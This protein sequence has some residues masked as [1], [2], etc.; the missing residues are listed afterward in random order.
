M[1]RN[2]TLFLITL[3]LNLTFIGNLNAQLIVTDASE[4]NGWTA[5]S[6]VRN[7]LLD[8]G[9][10]ISNAK[11]NG[12]DG[13]IDCNL[14]GKFETGSTPTNIG[15]ESGLILA[16]GGVSVAVGPNDTDEMIVPSTCAAYY[17]ENLASIASGPTTDVAVLEF[18]FIPWDNRVTFSFVFGS[19]EYMEW[20]GWD[21][22]D[23]FGFFVDGIN[24]AGSVYEHQNMA[25]VPGTAEIVSINTVNLNHN[26]AY[27]IDNTG[28]ATIQFDGFT[29]LMEVSFDVVPMSSYHIKM[30]ICDVGDDYADSGVFLKAHSFSTN[31]S[32]TM[33]IDG[34]DYTEIPEGHY[35][36]ANKE[37]EF[38]SVTNWNYDDVTWHFGDGTSAQGEQVTHTYSTDGFYT[39]TNVLHNPHRDM[40]S[41]FLTKVIEVRTPFSEE[42]ATACDSY[43][44][45]GTTYTESGTYSYI[46]QM[47]ESCDS[48]IILHLT[49]NPVD[50]TFLNVTACD[51]YEWYNTT[52]TEPGVYEHLEQSIAGCDSLLILNLD[53]NGSFSS[54]EEVTACNNYVWRG[55]TYMESGTYTDFVQA[56]GTCDSTFVLHLTI[57]Q[58]AQSDTT[59]IA[60]NTFTWHGVTYTASGDY[61][62]STQTVLGCDSIV[63]LH[64]TIGHEQVHP[65][66]IET[67]CEDSFTWHSHVY[68]HDGVYYDTIV[69]TT[70]CDEIFVL[71]LT[72]A[73]GYS[74]HLNETACNKYPWRSA[75]D[76]YLTESGHYTYESQ[77][78][79]GCDSIIDLDLTINYT[80]SPTEIYPM[81]TTNATPHWVVTATEFQINTYDFQLWD[82]NPK[83]IWDTVTWSFEEPMLWRLEPFG[84]KGKHCKMYVLNY[85]DD[86][87]WLT[88]RVSNRC[89]SECIEQRYWF[90]CSFYGLEETGS[91][92][93]GFN[94]I[95]NP[96]N[97]Q[98]KL[99]FEHLTGKVDVKVYDMTGCLIDHIQTYNGFETNELEYS[100]EGRAKGIYFFVA[101]G[102]EGTVSKKVVIR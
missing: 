4:L 98:M 19:E 17:D 94:V 71:D 26:S 95:P 6:L 72:F 18:D 79:N 30:A 89:T 85:V 60:C 83:C 78:Q 15:M 90:V 43:D 33:T 29:T 58:D 41:L 24:P 67:T 93:I 73:E 81:D 64:L 14:I 102:K 16:S 68:S 62:Y 10:T 8:N 21:Y 96:N 39:V 48:T 92:T 3:F 46:V 54:E 82:T 52:Y 34:W 74:I 40:D 11:F 47:P 84:D 32:Y 86:T 22:N 88:A 87:V 42:Y 53:I 101:A 1:K 7:I 61:L 100:L 66:Q 91:E 69:G 70:G 23:V 2:N 36:C 50:T 13:I 80:P 28:G 49:I 65:T 12:S 63:T 35:F 20:V 57:G 27:Y 56:P 76:G 59:A 38:N 44:W 37:I 77:A 97:S 75:N 25:L 5:D 31:F 51:E 99:V 9:V 55:T 45:H